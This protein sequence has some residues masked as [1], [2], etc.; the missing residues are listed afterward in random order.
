MI[1]GADGRTD[2]P[3]NRRWPGVEVVRAWV[4]ALLVLAVASAGCGDSAD[5]EPD[6][7][8]APTG[9]LPSWLDAVEPRPGASVA[10]DDRVAVRYPLTEPPREIRL[11]IDGVDVTAVADLNQNAAENT[12]LTQ[13]VGELVYAPD[14]L[15]VDAPVVLEPGQ[16]RVRA[17]L[18][19]TEFGE[20]SVELDDFSWTFQVL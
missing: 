7:G 6:V 16:H 5:D 8:V 4:V 12:D 1:A 20:Q 18:V 3:P 11:E 9:T 17:V 2:G 15:A 14:Q 13:T 19:R 10:P